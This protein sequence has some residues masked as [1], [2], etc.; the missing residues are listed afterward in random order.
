MEASAL[1][2]AIGAIRYAR[3]LKDLTLQQVNQ[4]TVL[5]LIAKRIRVGFFEDRNEALATVIIPWAQLFWGSVE[6]IISHLLESHFR[7][8]VRSYY[9]AHLEMIWIHEVDQVI[10]HRDY[11]ISTTQSWSIEIIFTGKYNISIYIFLVV[12]FW[13]VAAIR[14][15]IWVWGPKIY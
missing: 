3:K 5:R 10:N 12:V 1:Y 15:K 4:N 6:F 7:L 13:D 9:L 2:P 8:F 11:I 14:A